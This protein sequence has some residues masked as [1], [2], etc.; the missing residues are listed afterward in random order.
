[1]INKKTKPLLNIMNH[2][3]DKKISKKQSVALFV[4]PVA[5]DNQGG[6]VGGAVG[7]ATALVLYNWSCLSESVVVVFF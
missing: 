6:A 2:N 5:F 1:M 4:L 3:I 7:G